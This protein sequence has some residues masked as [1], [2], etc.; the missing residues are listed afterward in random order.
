MPFSALTLFAIP[1]VIVAASLLPAGLLFVAGFVF[2]TGAGIA[3][4]E[5]RREAGPAFR[6]PAHIGR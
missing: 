5:L 3:A 6:A 2:A 4:A 1:A